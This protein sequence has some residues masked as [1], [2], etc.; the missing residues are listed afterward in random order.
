MDQKEDI[1]CD[2]RCQILRE[3]ALQYVR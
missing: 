3:I 1:T 2:S